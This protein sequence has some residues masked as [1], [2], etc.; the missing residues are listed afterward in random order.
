[1]R[2]LTLA[3]TN[4]GPYAHQVIDFTKFDD[5]PV[6]LISGNTGAGKT[7]IFDAMCYALFGRT[8]S[9]ERPAETMHSDFADEYATTKVMFTFEHQHQQY[10]LTRQFKRKKHRKQSA[11][12]DYDRKVSLLYLDN[13]GNEHEITKTTEFDAFIKDLL[14]LNAEQFTQVVLLPQGKFRNFLTA[15]S[16]DKTKIL[17]ELFGTTIYDNWVKTLQAQLNDQS[18]ALKTTDHDLA[19]L[20]AQ[21]K[22]DD[23]EE[24]A[25]TPIVPWLTALAQ[26]LDQQR[27]QQQSLQAQQQQLQTQVTA[28]NEQLATQQQLHADHAQLTTLQHE[29]DTLLTQAPTIT[30][31]Q[32]QLA[33]LKWAQ[34]QQGTF[35]LWQEKTQQQ[36]A[37]Q[38]Q[39]KTYQTQLAALTAQLQAQQDQHQQ[40]LQ[41]QA[42]ITAVKDQMAV[43]HTKLALFAEIT[44]AQ[45]QLATLQ[46]QQTQLQAKLATLTD[47]CEQQQQQLTQLHDQQGQ[48]AT[49]S[50]QL[51]SLNQ[52]HEQVTADLQLVQQLITLAAQHTATQAALAQQQT[53]LAQAQQKFDDVNQAYLRG[54][55]I[56]LAKQ[57]KPDQPCPV[58]GSYHHPYPAASTGPTADEATFK[59]AQA[60]YQQAN[61]AYHAVKN[62]EQQQATQ[63]ATLTAQLQQR[64]LATTDWQ[65]LQHDLTTQQTAVAKQIAALQQQQTTLKAATKQ[66]AALTT[67]LATQQQLVQQQQQV[68]QQHDEQIN[69]LKTTIATKQQQLPPKFADEASLQAHL[70]ELQQQVTTFEQQLAANN[71]QITTLTAQQASLQA[72]LATTQANLQIVEQAVTTYHQQLTQAMTTMAGMTWDKL[73]TLMTQLDQIVVLEQQLQNYQQQKLSLRQQITQLQ[74]KLADQPL[75]DLEKLTQQAQQLQQQLQQVIA[76]VT[77]LS[78]DITTNQD[79]YAKVQQ[80]V[81]TQ[82]DYRDRVQELTN[83]VAAMS[84]NNEQHLTLERYVL[85]SYFQAVVEVASAKLVDLTD[86]R[87]Q[88][89][90]SNERGA[91]AARTG[92]ELDVYDDTVGRKRSVHTLS[93]GESFIVALALALSLGEV[94]QNQNGG[95]TMDALFIDEG[96]GSLDHH[97]LQLALQTLHTIEGQHRMIGIISHVTELEKQLPYQLQVI[98]KD[99][100]STIKYQ[101]G[102]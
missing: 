15:N 43:L 26:H 1:M 63:L 89:A 83:L 92:L 19:N 66:I 30:A 28:H 95:I 71:Q 91:I 38:Q 29:Y 12:A 2:P 9:R 36:Q 32:Q 40:L 69:T 56:N 48:L 85:R 62:D 90:L 72:Q 50:E 100:H 74:T 82:Q 81:T 4:F 96:F 31:Q 53:Q 22:W 73:T 101:L 21:V 94:I 49:I 76:Q 27:A 87:Y 75:L 23:D 79:L 80:L 17:R 58:C 57:L 51:V 44:T 11:K 39:I 97:A 13:E 88:L 102:E 18:A 7:T 67:A 45:Q 52:Q 93:G 98:A 86:G 99:G 34:Q 5:V 47:D 41:Q 77:L 35:S 24:P 37:D 20:Q 64:Q 65:A 59:A 6:F 8:S 46:A 14:H 3:M 70:D 60:A 16:T 61:H 55:I 84:G 68:V 42:A 10:Q 33:T 54:Q 25:T 78:N